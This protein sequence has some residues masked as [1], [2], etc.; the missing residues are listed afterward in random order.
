[1]YNSTT[2]RDQKHTVLN[3]RINLVFFSFLQ[4]VIDVQW[5]LTNKISCLVS[6]N[7]ATMLKASELLRVTHLPC[8]AHTLNL[9]VTDGLE[10]RKGSGEEKLGHSHNEEISSEED[11]LRNLLQKCRNIVRFFKKS[12]LAMDHLMKEQEKLNKTPLKPIQDVCTRW[13]STLYMLERLLHLHN[14]NCLTIALS[15]SANA[16]EILNFSDISTIKE[17]VAVLKPFE[18]ATKQV[19]VDKYVTVSIII[20]IV[21]G[22]QTSLQN[23]GT[24]LTCN[25]AKYLHSKLIASVIKRLF[26]YETRT[27]PRV[28]TLL[29]P[30]FKKHAFRNSENASQAHI[31]TQ[32]ELANFMQKTKLLS[33][34]GLDDKGVENEPDSTPST[35]KATNSSTCVDVDLF[36][37]LAQRITQADQI[38]TASSDSIILMRQYIESKVLPMD[39]DPIEY[40]S[41]QSQFPSAFADFAKKI[42]CIPATSVPSERIFSKTG[43]VI[44]ERRSN[45]KPKNVNILIF[46]GQN[47]WMQNESLE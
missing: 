13:N 28:A 40:W 25:I 29:D 19:S 24:G 12:T 15:N 45:L 27:V 8:F 9:T 39:T 2:N 16:P 23:V 18:E 38:S 43:Q 32:K 4:N 34:A 10:P 37:F 11:N 21:V 44:S 47:K 31:Y 35:S 14:D 42:L 7:A 3:N 41:S 17:I 46:V 26:S 22:I 1:M 36:G 30:R 20:P 33:N 6:D 5:S